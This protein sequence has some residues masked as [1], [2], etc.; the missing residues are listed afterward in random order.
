MRPAW[1]FVFFYLSHGL[2]EVCEINRIHH[3]FSVG[4]EKAQPLNTNDRIFFLIYHDRTVQY[5]VI[6]AGDVTEVNVYSQ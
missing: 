3:W 4:T 6:S 5:C 2:V 1:L